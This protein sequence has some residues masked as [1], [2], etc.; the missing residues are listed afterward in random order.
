MEMIAEFFTEYPII[1]QVMVII[2]II[3]VAY[4]I[5]KQFLKL[6]L[7]LLLIALAGAGYHY[8]NKPQKITEDV[9]KIK[10]IYKESKNLADKAMNLPKEI[11]KLLKNTDNESAN[12][13]KNK[14]KHKADEE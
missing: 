7:A 9:H 4:L 14:V 10:K 8:Y 2:F 13:R 1:F 6:S 11:N 3:F 12:K 5:F